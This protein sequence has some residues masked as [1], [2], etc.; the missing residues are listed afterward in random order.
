MQVLHLMLVLIELVHVLRAYSWLYKA[1][2]L[3]LLALLLVAYCYYNYFF[4][5]LFFVVLLFLLF[6]SFWI[7]I[8]ICAQICCQ[9]IKQGSQR[10]S[11]D[12]HSCPQSVEYDC[13]PQAKDRRLDSIYF[14]CSSVSPECWRWDWKMVILA[15]GCLVDQLFPRSFLCFFHVHLKVIQEK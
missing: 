13:S 1:K 4:L 12:M 2:L 7:F 10:P 9:L 6:S 11:L 8:L 3:I 14:L 15:K 5:I